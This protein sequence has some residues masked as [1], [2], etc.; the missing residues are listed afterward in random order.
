M[1]IDGYR[2]ELARP[3]QIHLLQEIERAAAALFPNDVITPEIRL[4]TVPHEQLK[5]ALV[6]ERLWTAATNTGTVVGFAIAM[7]EFNAAFLEEIDV[8]PTHQRKGLGRRLIGE[9]VCWAQA[10]KFSRVL[11]TTFEYVP[12]NAP[13]YLTL[14]F[15]KLAENELS[16]QLRER[17]HDERKRGMRQR[18]AMQLT[19]GA[20][21]PN[22]AMQATRE[23][24]RTC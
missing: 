1:S 3:E 16:S 15:R 14:G 23:D 11:L 22:N 21:Q 8:H 12:W 4:N 9:V 10:Q 18:V 7:R 20:E 19:L 24:A 6:D 2:V 17:L 5:T 13:F